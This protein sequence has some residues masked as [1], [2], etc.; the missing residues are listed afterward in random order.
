MREHAIVVPDGTRFAEVVAQLGDAVV[1][2]F[3][4]RLALVRE[5]GEW[6]N[7]PEGAF[8][9]DQVESDLRPN[10]KLFVE[11]WRKRMENKDR[12]GEG[13]PWDAPG[14]TPPG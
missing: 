12:P 5:V 7:L 9:V 13:L 10:E 14:F 6:P 3:P 11:A 1:Q 4:P 8:Y 2:L